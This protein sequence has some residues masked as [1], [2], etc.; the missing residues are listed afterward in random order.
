MACYK[1]Y[2]QGQ[3]LMVVVNLEQRI[4]LGAFEYALHT[5]TEEEWSCRRSRP[6]TTTT[7]RL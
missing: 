7:R 4:V 1:A 6:A 5:L 2:D 3:S